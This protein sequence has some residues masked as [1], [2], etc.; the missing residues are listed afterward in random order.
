MNQMPRLN[1]DGSPRDSAFKRWTGFLA[2][3]IIGGIVVGGAMAI[4]AYAVADDGTVHNG[5]R[6]ATPV[7]D[8]QWVDLMQRVRRNG[9]IGFGIGA[10]LASGYVVKCLLR[11]ED[12]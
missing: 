8:Q 6:D 12:P 5:R 4:F 2:I 10:A 9:L 1:P 3:M 7:S 11:D